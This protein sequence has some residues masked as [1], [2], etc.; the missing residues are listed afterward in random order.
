MTTGV[1]VFIVSILLPACFFLQE[2]LLEINNLRAILKLIWKTVTG[3]G[4][5]SSL[6]TLCL[7]YNMRWSNHS[8]AGIAEVLVHMCNLRE[9]FVEQVARGRC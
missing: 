8:F 6:T 2:T 5:I 1:D 9:D 3:A 7:K 4:L